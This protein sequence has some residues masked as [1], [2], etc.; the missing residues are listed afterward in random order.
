MSYFF[1]HLKYIILLSSRF[2]FFYWEFSCQSNCYSFRGNLSH[3]CSLWL[4]LAVI[5]FWLSV[6]FFLII[7][8][9]VHRVSWTCIKILF[10]FFQWYLDIICVYV[11][12]LQ[13]C[14]TLYNPIVA[15]VAPL[16][17]GSPEQEYWNALPCP[18][19]GDLPWTQFNLNIIYY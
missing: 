1:K 2:F 14:L 10:V 4:W 8:T 13:S 19:S 18:L 17:V 6:V 16:S 11:K 7:L 5:F 3:F 9:G 15:Y 12:S